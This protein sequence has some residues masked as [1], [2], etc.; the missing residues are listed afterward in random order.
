MIVGAHE[1]DQVTVGRFV[2]RGFAKRRFG[3]GGHHTGVTERLALIV[4][5]HQMRRRTSRR[6]TFVRGAN[7]E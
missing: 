2:E 3:I 4:G 5:N 6:V 1:G 7:P